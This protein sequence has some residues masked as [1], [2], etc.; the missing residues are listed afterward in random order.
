MHTL[1]IMLQES[2]PALLPILAQ[3]WGVSVPRRAKD[4]ALIE[5]LVGAMLD[6]A[7]AERVY[8]ALTDQERGVLQTLLG[9]KGHRMQIAIF[10]RMHGEIRRMGAGAIEREKPHEN[11]ISVAEALFY[12]GL[13]GLRNDKVGGGI[14]PVVYVPEDLAAVLPTHKTGYSADALAAEAPDDLPLRGAASRQAVTT[15]P[16]LAEVADVQAADTSVVDDMTTL[17]AYLQ[18]TSPAV[19]A[20][21]GL[22]GATRDAILPHLLVPDDLRLDFLLEVGL[23]A[24]LIELQG[25]KAFPK[26]AEVRRWL[27]E[28]R[29]AQLKWLADAWRGSSIYRDLWHTPGLH[30]EPTGWPYDPV[31][32]R[33]AMLNFLAGL[34]PRGEW[35]SVF[36]FVDIIKEHDPDFQRPGGDYQSWY[37]RNDDGEYLHGFESWDAVEGALLEFYL[38]GPLHWLGLVDVGEDAARLTAY[39]RAFL[40]EKQPWPQPSDPEEKVVVQPDGTLLASRKVS[41]LDRFQLARFTTWGQPA[42]RSGDPYT[43]V[44]DAAGIQQAAAQ[45]I[46]TGH[47]ASFIQRMLDN[48]ALP[49]PIAR[50]L[51]HWRSGP[52]ASVTV[53][54]LY[55]LRAT[56]PETL[57]FMYNTPQLRRFLGPRL[58]PM[59]GAVRADQLEGLRA[60]L[61]EH[62]IAAEFFED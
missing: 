25:A 37:I 39:G 57:D 43:Y 16:A 34:A 40:D 10:E 54:R 2:E 3:R 53:E 48:A 30:P 11:P 59:A 15:L 55:V 13:V 45:G 17:L 14:G 29:A 23:S 56:A 32:A 38:L 31:A 62:G 52:A 19:D 49:S 24:D 35:F 22:D 44:L 41:R 28:K 26:R 61:G 21:T 8:D 47:I 9:S 27:A 60:A 12:R 33:A 20:E 18:L 7:Q 36:E 51:E 46:N 6:T 4:A 50:L 42:T 58:G 5:A 1:R